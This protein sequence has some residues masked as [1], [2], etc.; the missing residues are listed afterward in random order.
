MLYPAR[1]HCNTQPAMSSITSLGPGL[2]TPVDTQ[3]EYWAT[4]WLVLSIGHELIIP[5]HISPKYAP[6]WRSTGSNQLS[7]LGQIRNLNGNR[8]YEDMELPS[9]PYMDVHNNIYCL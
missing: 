9:L 7:H 3:L 5:F 2:D 6:P 8:E 4:H 1:L